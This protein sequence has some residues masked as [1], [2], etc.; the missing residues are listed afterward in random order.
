MESP[1]NHSEFGLAHS[2]SD[3]KPVIKTADGQARAANGSEFLIN[4]YNINDQAHSN[5]SL[6]DFVPT[7]SAFHHASESRSDNFTENS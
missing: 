3:V 2:Q 4:K 5:S 6:D 1:E 7:I